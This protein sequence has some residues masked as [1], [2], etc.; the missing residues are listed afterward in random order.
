METDL[1]AAVHKERAMLNASFKQQDKKVAKYFVKPSENND[2]KMLMLAAD[3]NGQIEQLEALISVADASDAD[4]LKFVRDLSDID[5]D[6]QELNRVCA[7][8][9][10][11][12]FVSKYEATKTLAVYAAAYDNFLKHSERF[13]IAMRSL[14]T[15]NATVDYLV[16]RK[17]EAIKH[18][19]TLE[20]LVGLYNK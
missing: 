1:A 15:P 19:C 6:T 16:L 12:Y 20:Y 4:K 11:T 7:R 3:I 14:N 2:E 17:C 10:L 8:N 9:D 13:I 5:I 18:L